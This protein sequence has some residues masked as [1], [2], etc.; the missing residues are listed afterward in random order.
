M[1]EHIE[2]YATESKN[3][4]IEEERDT[5]VNELTKPKKINSCFSSLNV[6]LTRSG[7]SGRSRRTLS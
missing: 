7:T 1:N 3:K 5:P 6:N 2:E 4:K